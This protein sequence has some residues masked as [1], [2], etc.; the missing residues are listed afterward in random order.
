MR[1]RR[2]ERRAGDF[3]ALRRDEGGAVEEGAKPQRADISLAQR[4]RV[5][6]PG[7]RPA[8]NHQSDGNRP[9]RVAARERQRSIDRIDDHQ[10]VPRQPLGRVD[11]L[12]RKPCRLGRDR[13]HLM[14]QEPIDGEIRLGDRR[15]AALVGHCGGRGF[16]QAE[17]GHGDVAGPAR[18]ALEFW[19]KSGEFCLAGA[20]HEEE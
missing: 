16:A 7:D 18:D 2:D 12:F 9:A 3:G 5:D 10:G 20:H 11:A 13:R 19:E 1:T 6:D 17:I 14:E 8:A 4:R 15:A